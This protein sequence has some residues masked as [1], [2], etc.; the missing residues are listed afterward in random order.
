MIRLVAVVPPLQ[1]LKAVVQVYGEVMPLDARYQMIR[2][3]C[4]DSEE[5]IFHVT[6]DGLGDRQGRKAY[7]ITGKDFRFS[8]R[9]EP[10]GQLTHLEDTNEVV[11]KSTLSAG[12]IVPVL[13]LTAGVLSVNIEPWEAKGLQHQ[14][15]P[16]ELEMLERIGPPIAGTGVVA[17]QAGILLVVGT[18]TLFMSELK[19]GYYLDV[20][21][22]T[23]L[24]RRIDD[25]THMWVD[26]A[27]WPDTVGLPFSYQKAKIRTIAGGLTR[28]RNEVVA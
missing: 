9:Q 24:I 22:Y 2:L 21:G 10:V 14:D 5:L 12:G 3:T 27:P 1:T 26:P 4:G 13:P 19:P 28:I 25:D 7:D 11:F 23:V 6:D 16:W 8:I 18:G 17:V 15:L 20:G